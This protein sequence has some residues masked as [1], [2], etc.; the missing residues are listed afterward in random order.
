MKSVRLMLRCGAA[1]STLAWSTAAWSQAAPD[2]NAKVADPTSVE[3]TGAAEP[4]AEPEA[5][6]APA[7]PPPTLS[8]QIGAGKL[9]LE[10]RSRYETVDQT[11]TATLRDK[12]EA[13]TVRTRLGW[14]SAEFKGVKGLVEFEDVRQVGSE[15]F[16]VNVPGVAT[17]PLNGP[18]KAR[19]PIINDPDVTELNR[20]QLTWTP[21]AVAQITAGRQRILLDDQRFVGNVG[22]RQDEQTF[23]AIRADVAYGRFKATYAYVTHVNRILGELRDWD[24]D[25]HL[26]NAT[27]SPAEALRLQGFVYALDFGNSAINS[28]ITKGVKASGKTWLGLYQLAYNATFARQSDYRR[29]TVSYDLDY[30][31]ADLA[32]TFDIYTAKISYES[33]EGD[34]AR[35]FTTPLAT[36]H[37]FNGWSD[38]FTSPGG[39]KS[40]VDGF[41]DL[42]LSFNIKPR[43]R[44]SYFFNS[45]IVVRYHDF[46]DHKTGA[47]LGHEWDL[48]FTAAITTKL[49][50]QLKYAD[51]QR[52]KT[53]PVGTA[54]PPPSRTKTWLTL[55]YKF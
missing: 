48:Q 36:V 28:S 35:G 13:F 34:G 39:N 40:F 19:Y 3:Q 7:P 11:R 1:V 50:F 14:E 9:I 33:F 15:R 17:A 45:D 47:D 30:V 8:D 29:N 23:D 20:A 5:P 51:F 24:S 43:L 2:P 6:P 26:F 37:A 12:G 38:A 55:E 44:A 4:A 49:S 54:T 10:V 21:N 16:A 22:W 52:A 42:D 27:W 25:S 41:E 32:A 31:G 46:D 18:D 53:V